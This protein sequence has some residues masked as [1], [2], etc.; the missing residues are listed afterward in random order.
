MN[1][2]KAPAFRALS[3]SYPAFIINP[4]VAM[5]MQSAGKLPNIYTVKK[6]L[7]LVK[8]KARLLL[9]TSNI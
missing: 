6:H 5:I 8:K 9:F 3:Q 2:I 7:L 4:L 1:E